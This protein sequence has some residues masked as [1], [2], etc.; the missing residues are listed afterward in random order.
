MWSESSRSPKHVAKLSGKDVIVEA[1]LSLELYLKKNPLNQPHH[2]FRLF[3]IFSKHSWNGRQVE[4]IIAGYLLDSDCS[5]KPTPSRR[6][7]R[8]IERAS[9][10]VISGNFWTNEHPDEPADIRITNWHPIN[11]VNLKQNVNM[12]ITLFFY[13]SEHIEKQVWIHIITYNSISYKNS[14]STG[15]MLIGSIKQMQA[16]YLKSFLFARRSEKSFSST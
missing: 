4:E 5:L 3:R 11:Y 2:Q 15:D 13:G 12:L 9:P 7:S 10:Q 8:G 1:L 6:R 14:Y 16:P